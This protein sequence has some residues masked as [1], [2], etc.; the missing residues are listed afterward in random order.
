MHTDTLLA[1]KYN[2][3]TPRYTSYPTVP[4]WEPGIDPAE[5]QK[6]FSGRFHQGNR[7]DGL[8]LYIHLPFC[9][10][11][12]IY[13]GCNKKITTNHQVEDR[14]IDAVLQEWL[15]YRNLMEEPPVIREIHLGGGTPTFF[16]P[17]RLSRL[18]EGLL[19]NAILHPHHAFSL[20]GHP[21]NT[22]RSHLETLYRLGFRRVSY[23]VQ[24]TDPEV[25]KCITRLQPF[26]H[27]VAAA[28]AARETGYTSVNFDLVYG[29]PRQH[30]D[31]LVRTIQQCMSLRPD[32]I[33][34]YSYAHTP[35]VNY[36]QRLIDS[37]DLPS[38][39]KKLSLY[40]T[41]K[42]LLLGQGY[43]DIGMDHFALPTDELYEASG[44]G[45]LHRNFMGYTTRKTSLLLGLGV[46]SISDAGVAFAQNDKTLAG[47]YRAVESGRLAVKKGYFLNLEDQVFRQY[48]LDISCRGRTNFEDTFRPL[49]ET[50]SLPVLRELEK[51]GLV[52]LFE[53]GV[54]VTDRGRSFIRN[55]CKA[56]D[57][58]L[59]RAGSTRIFSKAI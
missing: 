50:Y 25:Q 13:C 8:S 57:L 44:N 12:C 43:R 36:G 14:Y 6:L 19:E 24:D 15:L 47:Y 53:K 10:S 34:F 51:D 31:S 55:I 16:A 46:S 49:L 45:T 17:A 28:E 23:G 42:E 33:A 56:F 40:L 5:W 41:G 35:E 54:E 32:R 59:L 38:A 9:E 11:L 52:C 18:I 48:I 58:H 4:Y 1:A 3:P 27:V 20:E 37:N 30:T 2:V 39:A 7:Q 26:Q 29:L 21:N 22:S